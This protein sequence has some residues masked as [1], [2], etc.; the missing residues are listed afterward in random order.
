MTD[1]KATP[2]QWAMLEE[3]SAPEYDNTILELRARVEALESKYET[4]RLATLEWGKDVDKLM[5][6][7]DQHLQR[8]MALEAAQQ[9]P[10]PIDEE[11]NDRRFHACMD[12]IRNATPEQIRAAAGLPERSSLV[13][14]VAWLLAQQF[15]KSRVG[16][17]CTPYAQAVLREVAAWL[18]EHY[19]G[20]TASST[21]LEQEAER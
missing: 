18:R 16:T 9:Q 19:G 2:E 15:S 1:H 17:D 14:R 11:E 6:W 4:M 20:P 10:E 13:D 7:S 21:A 5:C 3:R 8:I 12:L